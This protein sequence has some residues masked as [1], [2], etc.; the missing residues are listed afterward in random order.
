M[1]ETKPK[2]RIYMNDCGNECVSGPIGYEGDDWYAISKFIR[3]LCKVGAIQYGDQ[4]QIGVD[5]MW[6]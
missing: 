6:S 5:G 1:N 2:F 4:D 3:A